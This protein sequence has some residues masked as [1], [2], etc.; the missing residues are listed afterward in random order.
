M[1]SVSIRWYLSHSFCNSGRE[2]AFLRQCAVPFLVFGFLESRYD[3]A[4]ERIYGEREERAVR[5]PDTIL[6]DKLPHAAMAVL[7][8]AHTAQRRRLC[9]LRARAVRNGRSAFSFVSRRSSHGVYSAARC[10]VG[11][12][13]QC[14][15]TR[16]ILFPPRPVLS[17]TLGRWLCC[18]DT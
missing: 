14:K 16:V 13:C 5:D 8:L 17:A 18:F 10:L 9:G 12:P 11:G 7:A 2:L 1:P 3:V 15:S 4:A 6:L